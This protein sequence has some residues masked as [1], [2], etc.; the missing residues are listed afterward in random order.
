MI[1][2]LTPP[3]FETL[4]IEIQGGIGRLTLTRPQKLNA[5]SP[6]TLR[7][8]IEASRWLAGLP[9]LRV[10]LV[11]GEGRAFCAGFDLGAMRDASRPMDRE[12]TDLG[13]RM[14]EAV[15]SIPAITLAL[16]QGHCVGGGVLLA[17]ACDLR[18][19]AEDVRFSIP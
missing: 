5:L 9:E 16:V 15:E 11:A 14:V 8:L 13:R 12:A 17:G 2:D 4:S 19:V 6:L 3:R 10:L 7:E 1:A 18:M